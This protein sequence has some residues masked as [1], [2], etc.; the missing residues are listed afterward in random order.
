MLAWMPNREDQKTAEFIGQNFL[1]AKAQ[2]KEH[3]AWFH[4]FDAVCTPTV[5]LL[6]SESKERA[7]GGLSAQQRLR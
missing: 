6:D 3:P 7:T 5:L 2:I 4:R 1:P